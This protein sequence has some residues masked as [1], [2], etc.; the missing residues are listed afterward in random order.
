MQGHA[1]IDGRLVSFQSPLD[2]QALE[3]MRVA[4][5]LQSARPNEPVTTA[6]D[7]EAARQ[8]EGYFAMLLVREMPGEI[9]VSTTFRKSM[10]EGFFSGSGSDVYGSW[11]DEHIGAA[12]AE[13]D[14]L[15]LA[16]LVKT[17]IAREAS[18]EEDGGS[19]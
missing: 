9:P 18:P 10:P 6:D 14:G 8:L 11:F 17:A 13:R 2:A 1:A 4:R 15:G 5:A 3:A 12:L 16:G 19:Q 7:A